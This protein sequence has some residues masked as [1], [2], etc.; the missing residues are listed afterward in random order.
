MP[1]ESIRCVACVEDVPRDAFCKEDNLLKP[2]EA[3]P[4]GPKFSM[5]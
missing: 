5:T 4:S 2:L 3:A 1:E